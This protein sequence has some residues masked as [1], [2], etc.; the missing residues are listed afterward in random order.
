MMA[1][2]RLFCGIL[3]LIAFYKSSASEADG[4]ARLESMEGRIKQLESMQRRIEKLE[5]SHS[6]LLLGGLGWL[7]K[8][9]FLGECCKI[10]EHQAQGICGKVH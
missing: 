6:K 4:Q 5:T 9:I 1:T 7:G 10:L 8:F 2:S 3:L